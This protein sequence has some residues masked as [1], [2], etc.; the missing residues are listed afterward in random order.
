M[1][2][3]GHRWLDPSEVGTRTAGW[4]DTRTESCSIIEGERRMMEKLGHETESINT[5][6]MAEEIVFLSLQHHLSPS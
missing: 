2:P 6:L 1:V 3:E 4:W 5:G